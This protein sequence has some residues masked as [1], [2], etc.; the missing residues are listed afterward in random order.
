MQNLLIIL[1]MFGSFFSYC[2]WVGGKGTSEWMN[3]G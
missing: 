2:G 1:S 3:G